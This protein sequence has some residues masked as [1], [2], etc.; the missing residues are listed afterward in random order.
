MNFS[1]IQSIMLRNSK[2]K[3]G[4]LWVRQPGDYQISGGWSKLDA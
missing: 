4:D 1:K 3:D 2:D